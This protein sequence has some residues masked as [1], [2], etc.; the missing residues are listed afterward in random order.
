MDGLSDDNQFAFTIIAFIG[1]VFSPYYA[2]SGRHDPQNH[3]SVNVALYGKSGKR[4]AMTE[5]GRNALSQSRNSLEIRQSDL[6]WSGSDLVINVRERSAPIPRQVI[7]SI[8][9]TP[10]GLNKDSFALD[11]NGKHFWHPIA[12][13]ARFVVDLKD[14]EFRSSGSAYIDSN[15]G[16]EPLEDA[17]DYWDWSRAMTTSGSGICYD[18][19][20]KSG[21]KRRSAL[22]FNKSGD[23]YE[24]DMP[25]RKSL[26]PGPIWRVARG[27]PL[28]EYSPVKTLSVLE[29]TPFYTRSKISASFDGENVIAMHESLD[30]NRFS[31]NWVKCLLPFRMPRITI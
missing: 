14:P 1:S 9:I 29:D 18:L 19:I 26:E 20:S 22:R 25:L 4:W 17:F 3:V 23:W 27:A 7:G 13:S 24:I 8:R 30:L 10:A 15:W 12:P 11:V 28:F 16:A 2:W 6:H 31:Q 5:R 21:V